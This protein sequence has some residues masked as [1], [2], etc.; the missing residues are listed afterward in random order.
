MTAVEDPSVVHADLR[1]ALLEVFAL[2]DGSSDTR[3]V[4]AAIEARAA[5]DVADADPAMRPSPISNEE[6]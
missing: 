5:Q 3:I 6:G 4:L 1:A 2:P